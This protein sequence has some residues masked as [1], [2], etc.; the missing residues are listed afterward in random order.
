MAK[1]P[2]HIEIF[3]TQVN[4][5]KLIEL[6]KISQ[7]IKKRCFCSSI[8]MMLR[9]VVELDTIIICF[10]KIYSNLSEWLIHAFQISN[11]NLSLSQL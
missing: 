10:I 11:A 7:S 9:A 4:Y 6:I 1:T 3:D 2:Q 8:K 5:Y